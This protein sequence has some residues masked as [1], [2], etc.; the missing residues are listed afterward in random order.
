MSTPVYLRIFLDREMDRPAIDRQREGCEN[1]I[2][3]QHWDVVETYID[4]SISASGNT[5]KR[6]VYEWIGLWGGAP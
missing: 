2:K 5:A 3:Y 6:P 4:Q 1:L